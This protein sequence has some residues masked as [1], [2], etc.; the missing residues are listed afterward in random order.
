MEIEASTF[1]SITIDGEKY[2]HDVVIFPSRIERR[3]KWITKDEHG[4]SHKFTRK[5]MEEYLR[6]VDTDQIEV[7]VV[8]T[9]QYGRLGLLDEAKKLLEEKGIEVVELK[10]PEAAKQF[11]RREEPRE[12]KLGIFHVTC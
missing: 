8:G 4:T 5:E 11:E 2:D 7:V 12:R 10:T 3:K 6:K 1:G 9:G